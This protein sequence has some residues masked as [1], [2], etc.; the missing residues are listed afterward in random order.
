MSLKNLRFVHKRLNIRITFLSSLII[1]ASL[2]L[3]FVLVYLLL[4][5][6]LRR[7]RQ[8]E[9]K[10]RLLE[11][12]AQYQTGGLDLIAKELSAETRLGAADVFLAR[13]AGEDGRT[14][15]FHRPKEWASLPLN[16]IEDPENLKPDGFRILRSPRQSFRI[17]I[18]SIRLPDGNFLQVGMST[19]A[20][21]AT[22]KRFR[23]TFFIILAPLVLLSFAGGSLLTLQSIRPVHRLTEAI[24][25]IIDTNRMN[26]RIP[27]RG[28]EDDLDRLVFLFNT[29]LDRIDQLIKGMRESLDNVG[30]DLR[31]PL[32][33]LRGIAELGI[34]SS[35]E[36][37]RLKEVLGECVEETDRLLLMIKALMDITEAESG[38]MKLDVKPLPVAAV[39][40]SVTDMYEYIAEEKNIELKTDVS[41]NL[42]VEADSVRIKQAVANLIDNAIKYTPSGGSVRIEAY[43][44]EREL[45]IAVSD[46]G[47]GIRHSE[48]ESIWDRLYRS[49][50]SRSQSGHGLGLSLVKAVV[51]AHGGSVSVTSEVGQ[52]S[53]F[54]LSFPRGDPGQSPKSERAS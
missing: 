10:L 34:Q 20:Q 21:D 48:L 49:D 26:E 19:L 43:Q 4:S 33:R 30:H 32:T 11:T 12:W 47:I 29:M 40:K 13:V 39:V 27:V 16:H 18:S 53:R 23:D 45:A 8:A 44:N 42:L 9:I 31:T 50:Q 7:E 46:T 36:S 14:L 3:M 2:L 51:G 25:A 24:Q 38:I 6:S 37:K 28:T 1:T 41:D 15:L 52:G 35:D 17:E 54:V 22:L 5:N